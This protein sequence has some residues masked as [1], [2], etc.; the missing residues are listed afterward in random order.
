[1]VSVDR[2]IAGYVSFRAVGK[3]K[4]TVSVL[5][6]RTPPATK[7]WIP[8]CGVEMSGESIDGAGVDDPIQDLGKN[9]D[10]RVVEADTAV[11][12]PVNAG[13]GTI[14]MEANKARYPV[15]S[16]RLGTPAVNPTASERMLSITAKVLNFRFAMLLN[17]TSDFAPA[18]A[19]LTR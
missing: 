2:R 15:S 8:L 18:T 12:A 16:W 17:E 3:K 11:P 13:N 5:T 9:A 19:C 10:V 14:R 1:M 6:S 4:E 7:V